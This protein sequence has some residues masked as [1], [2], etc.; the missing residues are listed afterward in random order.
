MVLYRSTN[1]GSCVEILYKYILNSLKNS[2]LYLR[3][4]YSSWTLVGL[5][6][7]QISVMRHGLMTRVIDYA[8]QACRKIHRGNHP[9]LPLPQPSFPPMTAYTQKFLLDWN[10][11]VALGE[12]FGTPWSYDNE[13]EN[14][15]DL[16]ISESLNF[17]TKKNSVKSAFEAKLGSWKE[18][19]SL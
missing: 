7:Q 9:P 5:H 8:G 6:R 16:M 19:L 14:S 15:T 4:T 10:S 1:P 13:L 17:L 18:L 12:N 2:K 11:F 3:G